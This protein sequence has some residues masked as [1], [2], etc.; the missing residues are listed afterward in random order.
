MASGALTPRAR[1]LP[2]EAPAPVRG[3]PGQPVTPSDLQRMGPGL[4]DDFI[5]D[6]IGGLTESLISD[7]TDSLGLSICRSGDTITITAA[8]DLDFATASQL[9]G[10]LN[11]TFPQL[12]HLP[13]NADGHGNVRGHRGAGPAGARVV[14]D[15]G[16]IVFIDAFGLGTLVT[17]HNWA[18]RRHLPFALSNPSATVRRLLAITGLDD[19]F[20][21]V[22]DLPGALGLNGSVE[23]PRL[24]TTGSTPP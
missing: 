11:S 23:R 12:S 22:H 4:M 8:G 15:V 6:H 1:P 20:A 10:C 24:R 17:M 7:G 3:D 14:I 2:G 21:V 13:A 9:L 19:H 18:H 5:G 16:G